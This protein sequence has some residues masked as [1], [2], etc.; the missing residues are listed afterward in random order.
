MI[1]VA[2]GLVGEHDGGFADKGAGDPVLLRGHEGAVWTAVFTPDGTT[3]PG[4]NPIPVAEPECPRGYLPLGASG[5]PS[6]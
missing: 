6:G 5:A 2:G 1:E 3:I 4:S